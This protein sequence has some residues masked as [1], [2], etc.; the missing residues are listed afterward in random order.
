MYVC[1]FKFFVF[2]LLTSLVHSWIW[3]YTTLMHSVMGAAFG[4]KVPAYTVILD[5]D[6]KIRDFPVPLRFRPCRNYGS[7]LLR[8][9]HYMQRWVVLMSKES[10]K[11]SFYSVWMLLQVSDFS[12]A[13]PSSSILCSSPPRPA[14]GSGTSSIPTFCDGDVS[15]GLEDHAISKD[16]EDLRTPS[17]E[18]S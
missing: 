5:L 3:Q 8:P 6:R 4:V 18:Q 7:E 16:A 11:I 2:R 10:G 12:T 14:R 9:V 17:I 1:L 13:K 15:V